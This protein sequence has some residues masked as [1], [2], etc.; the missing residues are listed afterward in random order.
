MKFNLKDAVIIALVITI[1]IMLMKAS[2][3]SYAD[4]V[5]ELDCQTEPIVAS[6]IC[7]EVYPDYPEV[8]EMIEDGAKKYCCRKK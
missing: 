2:R 1:V 3:R 4:P 6:K 7:S 5:G 8:G